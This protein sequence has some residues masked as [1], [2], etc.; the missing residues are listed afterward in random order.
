MA[1]LY[2]K[3]RHSVSSA[4]LWRECPSAFLWR[5]GLQRWG[6]DNARTAMG[7]AAEKAYANALLHGLTADEAAEDAKR[8]FYDLMQ[9][10]DTEHADYAAAITKG[11]INDTPEEWGKF[12]QHAPWRPV[13]VAI[14]G[15]EI[16][17]KPDF[18]F[19]NAL[20]DTKATLRIPSEPSP[21]HLRQIGAYAKEWGLP[22]VLFYSAPNKA[23][24]YK[25]ALHP[26]DD[27]SAERVCGE[28]MRDWRQIEAFDRRFSSVRDAALVTPLNTDSFYWDETD[29]EEAKSLWNEACESN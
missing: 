29:I 1:V 3:Y 16:S 22:G 7:Q 24:E 28:L 19:E 6:K 10:E 18:I 8:R 5:Y 21:L 14:L 9:G 25:T 11:F 12:V 23:A 17:L 20:V 27:E 2:A 13:Q 15:K 26:I 4:N